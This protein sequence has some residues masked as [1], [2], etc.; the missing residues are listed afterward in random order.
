MKK[1]NKGITLIALI[2]TIIVL[3]I[4]AGVSIS[5]LSGDGIFKKA[6]NASEIYSEKSAKEKLQLHLM[7]LLLEKQTN[8]EYNSNEFLT[9]KLQEKGFIVNNDIVIVDGY[10]FQI[11]RSVP[12]IVVGLGKGEENNE[13]QVT[14]EQT[15]ASDYTKSTLKIGIVTQNEV[16]EVK[17]SGESVDVP[18]PQKDDN[19]KNTYTIEKEVTENKTYEFEVKATKDGK[20]YTTTVIANINNKTYIKGN[21]KLA[22]NKGRNQYVGWDLI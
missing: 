4:L 1:Q 3:L 7:N 9:A 5:A 13:M 22:Y 21:P 19:N 15:L 12:D 16:T 8:S 14:V 6:T 11:D 2:I 10:K 17:V 18:E 20:D